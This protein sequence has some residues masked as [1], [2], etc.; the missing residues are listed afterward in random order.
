VPHLQ[1]YKHEA[2]LSLYV[3]FVVDT[4][5]WMVMP[6]MEVG[7]VQWRRA[8]LS[9]TDWQWMGKLHLPEPQ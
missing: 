6:Y 7:K 9:L 8:S 1:A 3:S 5:L 4:A 2:I